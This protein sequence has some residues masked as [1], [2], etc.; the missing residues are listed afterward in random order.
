MSR[1]MPQRGSSQQQLAAVNKKETSQVGQTVVDFKKLRKKDNSLELL[2]NFV[3]RR[4]IKK[5]RNYVILLLTLV[6]FGLSYSG[7]VVI[8]NLNLQDLLAGNSADLE[9]VA[10]LCQ[11]FSFGNFDVIR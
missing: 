6:L 3:Q 7:V 11:V 2:H 1:P 10:N 4:K 5:S 9:E 8:Q